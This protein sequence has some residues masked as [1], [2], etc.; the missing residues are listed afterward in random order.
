LFFKTLEKT[1]I[2]NI[3]SP[4]YPTQNSAIQILI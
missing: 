2:K 1:M 3:K 4:V